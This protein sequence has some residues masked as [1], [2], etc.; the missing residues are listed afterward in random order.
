MNKRP[1]VTI[2]P[3]RVI[4]QKHPLKLG[5]NN[6]FQRGNPNRVNMT[7]V[8]I[9]VKQRIVQLFQ[10]FKRKYFHFLVELKE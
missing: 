6:F 10:H 9:N 2:T 5:T 7:S 4:E 8:K 1:Q 3:K